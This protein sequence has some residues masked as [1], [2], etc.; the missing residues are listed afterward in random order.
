[1]PKITKTNIKKA[2]SWAI[3]I[4]SAFIVASEVNDTKLWWIQILAMATLILILL[5]NGAYK[6]ESI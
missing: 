5:W 6:K 1:M 3:G 2:I 4:P